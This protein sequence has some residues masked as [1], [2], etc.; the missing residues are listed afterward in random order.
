MTADTGQTTTSPVWG[1]VLVG[2]KSS[3]MGWP[4]HLLQ[5]DGQTW[6]ERT[7]TL[8]RLRTEQ[9][10]IAG[11]G[12]L[13]PVLAGV[14]C[15]DDI[16]GLEGPLAGILSAFRHYPDVSWLMAACDLPDL[17]EGALWW[18]LEHRASGVLA[19]LPDLANDG[20][21]EPLL[22]YYDRQCRPL[23][24]TM[25]ATGQMRMQWLRQAAGVMTPQPPAV[26]RSSWRN[27]NT[28]EELGRLV[29]EAAQKEGQNLAAGA[30]R[31]ERKADRSGAG[32]S[33]P[34]QA[35]PR[36]V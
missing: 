26:L 20:R 34:R 7:I 30:E 18:L 36:T 16:P 9:V 10:I 6:I 1:C 24:E 12:S 15:V 14:P 2:G 19:I 22:A 4:K 27:V 25:A 23:L 29:R 13:P 3:R 21:V 32:Q 8:L 35:D 11:T 33:E 31:M 28:P 5:R 17:E